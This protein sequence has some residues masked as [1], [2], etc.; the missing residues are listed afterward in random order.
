[1]PSGNEPVGFRSAREHKIAE[2]NEPEVMRRH[3]WVEVPR[4]EWPAPQQEKGGW[5]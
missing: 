3:G 1:M 4:V 5:K 2:D